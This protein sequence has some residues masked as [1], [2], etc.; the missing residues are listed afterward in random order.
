VGP[1]AGILAAAPQGVEVITGESVAVVTSDVDAVVVIVGLT[2]GDEGEEWTGA[3][4]REDLELSDEQNELVQSAIDLERP[5][6]VV[7]EA[8]SVVQMPWI[9]DVD[10]VVMAWYPGERGGAAL[11]RL[12]FGQV[13]FSGRLPVTWPQSDEQLPTFGDGET[14]EMDYYVGYRRFD[15]MNLS[16]LYAWGHGLSYSEFTF[17]RLHVPCAEVSEESVIQ[18]EVDVRNLSEVAGDEVVFVFASHPDTEARRSVKELKGFARVQLDAGE[19]KRVTI[20][21]RMQDLKYWDDTS[22]AWVVEKGPV[23]FSVGKSSDNLVL[24]Q[25]VTV[26]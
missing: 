5:V 4:D 3:G 11:G 26:N 7:V 22:N 18:V 15:R 20:P 6:I 9:G 2:P 13:N 14:E 17:E 21:V 19:A 23:L 16:P 12:L 25:T 10:A 24:E 8:G 1:F